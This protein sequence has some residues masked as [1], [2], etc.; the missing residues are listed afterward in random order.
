MMTLKDLVSLRN[1]LQNTLDI[2]ILLNE[3]EKNYVRLQTL[4][5]EASGDIVEQINNA[6]MQ[7]KNIE[8]LLH[9]D[10]NTVAE[11]VN[12]VQAQIDVFTEKFF[13]EGYRDR[14]KYHNTDAIRKSRIIPKEDQFESIILQRINLH[15]T[16]EYPALEIGCG[17]GNWTKHLVASDPL[18]ISDYHA[19]FLNTAMRQFPSLYQGRMR[20]YTI[21]YNNTISNLPNNQFGFIFSYN[22][23]NYSCFNTIK[24]FLQQAYNWL[25]PGGTIL[26]TYNNA[27]M[28][29]AAAYAENYFMSY[30]PKKLLVPAAEEIGFE[31]IYSFDLEPAF[32]VIEFKKPGKLTTVKAGQVIGEIKLKDN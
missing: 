12:N 13:T 30:A 20:R 2:S 27:D 3:L 25:K 5:T 7:H 18:Y 9:R 8:E 23:F 28:P 24:K 4:A 22:F 29:A 17:D 11:L 15:S 14:L 10:V 21:D 31:M 26:F 16:W 32:S 1:E 6:A 19:D